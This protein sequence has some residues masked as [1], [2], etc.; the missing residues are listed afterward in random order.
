M[1]RFE[2]T[3]DGSEMWIY[4]WSNYFTGSSFSRTVSGPDLDNKTSGKYVLT[5][6]RTRDQSGNEKEVTLYNGGLGSPIEN[7]SFNYGAVPTD[8]SFS[9]TSIAEETLGASLGEVKVNGVDNDGLYTLTITGADA[10]SLEISSKGYLRLKDNVKLDYE[11]KTTLEFTITA[12]NA[13]NDSYSENFTIN[14]IDNGLS[15]SSI[16]SSGFI[17]IDIDSND[18]GISDTMLPG[19]N[20]GDIQ[21][22]LTN[23]SYEHDDLS[24]FGIELETY[25]S[26]VEDLLELEDQNNE[27]D[28]A[29]ELEANINASTSNEIG[30]FNNIHSAFTP[31][32]D[33]ED[34]LIINEI[35]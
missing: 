2:N 19:N 15:G 25:D 9:G 20:S 8:I 1:G 5:Q 3:S 26:E 10:A 30:S 34:L 23:S 27:L 12:K 4:V 24:E 32:Q 31:E 7:L 16:A 29:R 18:L 35:I 17:V 13:T 11:T 28:L 21:K 14:V 33:E 22:G 6:L